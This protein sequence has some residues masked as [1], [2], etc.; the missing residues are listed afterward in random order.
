MAED[1]QAIR[2][3]A[4]LPY[5]GV[6]GTSIVIG[7]PAFEWRA[8]ESENDPCLANKALLTTNAIDYLI[9]QCDIGK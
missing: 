8:P 5:E 9:G 6:K 1:N 3:A 2:I 4:F 7:D